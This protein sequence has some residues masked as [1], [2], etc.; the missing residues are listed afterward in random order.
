MA[1]NTTQMV[2]RDDSTPSQVMLHSLNVD[3]DSSIKEY[4]EIFEGETKQLAEFSDSENIFTS[5]YRRAYLNEIEKDVCD[6]FVTEI[7]GILDQERALKLQ[8]QEKYQEY[9]GLSEREKE[10]FLLD[11]L[12]YAETIFEWQELRQYR[13]HLQNEVISVLSLSVSR[14]GRAN[15]IDKVFTKKQIQEYMDRSVQK[16][17]GFLD[18]F[19]EQ[20]KP[21]DR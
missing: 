13:K 16:P 6:Q 18:G 20:V 12:N 2:M 21:N 19:K 4:R 8:F 15:L 9:I 17:P 1:E 14:E 3:Y 11:N 7:S 5:D 10:K